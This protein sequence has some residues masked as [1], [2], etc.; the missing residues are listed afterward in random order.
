MVVQ[1]TRAPEAQEEE[2]EA[3]KGDADVKGDREEGDRHEACVRGLE[4]TVLGVLRWVRR[5][6][7]GMMYE[8][9][10][11]D[12]LT[13]VRTFTRSFQS[14]QENISNDKVAPKTNVEQR[15]ATIDQKA[16]SMW[17][18]RTSFRAFAA[19]LM[20][21]LSVRADREVSIAGSLIGSPC[22]AS[23]CR[24]ASAVSAA[25]AGASISSGTT[26]LRDLRPSLDAVS[27]LE[28][29]RECGRDWGREGGGVYRARLLGRD[30]S[31]SADIRMNQKNEMT[32]RS[33]RTP[34][35]PAGTAMDMSQRF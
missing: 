29:D 8:P 7:G 5:F 30:A 3:D 17:C 20:F 6:S 21:V 24:T 26:A 25:A 27:G 15:P 28:D 16:M 23:S 11:M 14:E 19:K 34:Q 31:F 12:G 35:T 18:S 1:L 4:A 22:V 10:M 33:T 2:G 9:H 32:H 13:A